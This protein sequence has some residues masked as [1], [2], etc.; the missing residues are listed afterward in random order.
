MFNQAQSKESR[1]LIIFTH[2]VGRFGNQSIAYGH[3]IA[4]L[5]ENQDKFDLIN[6]AFWDYAH[7]LES[8]SKS[9][10]CTMPTEHQRWQ[11]FKY[12]RYLRQ[13]KFPR[14]AER[15]RTNLIRLIYAIY[16]NPL[17]NRYGIQSVLVDDTSTI[18]N[19]MGTRQDRLDLN[20]PDDLDIFDRSDV[21][22]L[23]GWGIRSW[24]LFEKHQ[25]SIRQ[26]MKIDHKYTEIGQK[27]IT[28]VRNSCDFI[29]GVSIRQGDYQTWA[30]GKYF[31]RV[32][33]YIEWMKQAQS[34]FEESYQRI[35]FVIA[36]DEPQDIK[37][38][39]G[40]NVYFSTGIAGGSGHYIESIVELSLC[41]I[42][43][44]PPSTFS[45]WAA[46]MGDIP[47]LAVYERDQIIDQNDVQSRHIYDAIVHP[48][49]SVSVC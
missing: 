40:L 35:G 24:S 7:L 13:I 16:G 9:Q 49:L 29:I 38:F 48:H 30:N 25:N 36:S 33:Q 14:G 8:T 6:M 46:F 42:I 11:Y 27:F 12:I 4:F 26:W 34:I 41:D 32:E 22:L 28:N 19:I 3:L 20:N 17:S 5:L 2:G 23:A 10:L 47:I 43:M 15:F 18:S 45:A 44:T 1:K 31:F 39:C 21:T 37:R